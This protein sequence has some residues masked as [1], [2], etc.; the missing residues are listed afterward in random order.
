MPRAMKLP[1]AYE[2]AAALE[3]HLGDPLDPG[4][5]ISFARAMELDEQELYPEEAL[6]C[7]NAWGL[8]RFYVPMALGGSLTTH[9][10]VFALVRSVA[11]RDLT[12]G[13]A[14]ALSFAPATL[15]WIAGDAHVKKLAADHL[16]AGG[17]IA[18][19]QHE[20]DH[21]D[22]LLSDEVSAVREDGAFVVNGEKWVVGNLRRAGAL[23]LYA[24]TRPDGGP[25]G[26]SLIY[27]DKAGLGRGTFDYIAKI[28]SL[29]V[30]G[31]E[32]AAMSFANARVP[33]ENLIGR[34]GSAIDLALRCSQISRV[35]AIALGIGATDTALRCAVARAT[36][37]KVYGRTVWSI[38]AA[39]RKL[40]DGFLDL[41]LVECAAVASVRAVEAAPGRASVWA[42]FAKTLATIALEAIVLDL[43]SVLGSRY[44]LREGHWSGMFQKLV[45]DVPVIRVAHY[46]G[47]VSH[48]HLAAQLPS[49]FARPAG[50][51]E[52]NLRPIFELHAAPP[53]FDGAK[54]EVFA[55]KD[56]MLHAHRLT[57]HLLPALDLDP[58][59]R[60]ELLPLE[61]MIAEET[62]AIARHFTSLPRG[63]AQ[64]PELFDA[65]KR[66]C[67]LRAC[68]AAILFFA[69][70]R[71][72]LDPFFA[73]GD[74]LIALLDRQ[75]RL[76][77]PTF[78]PMPARSRAA[79]ADEVLRR[80]GE[81]IL[82]SMIPLP[83]T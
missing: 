40:V 34:E 81:K 29:G 60:A 4:S 82:F 2:T 6:A 32:L 73:R 83:I 51:L 78:T 67:T 44:Y 39:Q 7:L 62:D 20:R 31:Q 38:P 25:R 27:V 43:S 30:R 52:E 47:V 46:G 28:H 53:P 49:L 74:W 69:F 11:R 70:N 15:V 58:E 24:R 42:P 72:A 61:R 5:R 8:S 23:V 3:Q 22:D 14:H 1:V 35:L 16:L 41:I 75:M 65:T 18:I 48:S 13:L 68:S 12:A 80:Y 26:F 50:E 17:Q 45:R 21:G 9:E 59:V 63:A 37:R 79:V 76:L 36:D 56:E 33:A 64:S 10:E 19:A 57:E 77:R 55:R 71:P 66:Y 54:L